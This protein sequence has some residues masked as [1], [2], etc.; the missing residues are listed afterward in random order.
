MAKLYSIIEYSKSKY[1]FQIQITGKLK[2]C[3]LFALIPDNQNY[4]D[5]IYND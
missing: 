4:K 3:C 1:S 2:G 5:R